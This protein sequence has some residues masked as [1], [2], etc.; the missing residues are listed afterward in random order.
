MPHGKQTSRRDFLKK[1][2]IL[3]GV[4]TIITSQVS[5]SPQR[6]AP[7]ERITVGVIGSGKRGHTLMRGLRGIGEIQFVAVAEVE[8]NR[9]ASAKKLAEDHH[10]KQK[11][12]GGFKG[13]DTYGNF[14][15]LL[16]RKDIDAVVIATPDHW[17]A[18][19]VVEAA[20]AKKDIYCEKPLSLT[21]REARVMADTV[22]KEGVIFQPG[23]QQRSECGGRFH[24]A[25]ELVR[26]GRIG[27][28]KTVHVG[29]GGPSQDCNLPEQPTPKDADWNM[30]LGPAPLRGYHEALC[31][32]G[33]HGHY[34]AWRN[35]KPY[36]GGGMTDWGAHH[37]DIAQWGLGM[38][39]SG[40]V[41][42][43]A[44][45]GK[46]FKQLTYR[47][48]NGVVMYHGGANGVLF[49]GTKGKIEVNRGL[50]RSDPGDIL[51]EKIGDDEIRLYKTGHHMRNWPECIR[52]R[53]DTICTAES[54]CCSVCVCHLGN[55]AF[56][57]KC[58]LKW[59]PKAY[60]FLEN[61]EANTWLDRER[62]APWKLEG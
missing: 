25:C 20:R 61:E 31:P 45:D 57:N 11:D 60:R 41:E 8:A 30:W 17:H 24:R 36:S 42:I 47:Y 16:A 1:G 62:R 34:P 13:V 54:G 21:I 39:E 22:K 9:R 35:Y 2:A 29:V 43:H 59:D 6:P 10:S 26:N 56:W 49:T 3:A 50:L 19:P 33:V 53:K 51:K 27:E 4:P 14:R 5:A 38:D 23:S 44:P 32:K 15:Q 58:S 40:P 12:K 7:S 55:L 28:I 37:F 52:S 46:E 18:I 48:A